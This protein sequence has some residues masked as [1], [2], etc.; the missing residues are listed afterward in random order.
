MGLGRRKGKEG[1]GEKRV[2][3]TQRGLIGAQDK[4]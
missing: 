4:I 3:E 2:T 1:Q